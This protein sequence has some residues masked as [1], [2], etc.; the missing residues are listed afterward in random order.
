MPGPLPKLYSV[1][2]AKQTSNEQDRRAVPADLDQ[3]EPWFVEFGDDSERKFI[4]WW[5]FDDA[6]ADESQH[7]NS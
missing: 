2:V 7:S 4:K 5:G 6:V 1:A 3:P